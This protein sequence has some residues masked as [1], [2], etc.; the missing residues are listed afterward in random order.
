MALPV[1]HQSAPIQNTNTNTIQTWLLA[2]K[3]AFITSYLCFCD[4][5]L[6]KMMKSVS[7]QQ[8][9]IWQSEWWQ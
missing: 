1:N 6:K 3:P 7:R 4:K 5:Y 2:K 8:S 9:D